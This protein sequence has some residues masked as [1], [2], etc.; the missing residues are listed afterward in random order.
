MQGNRGWDSSPEMAVR[1]AVH[2]LGLRYRV[3]TRPLPALNRRADLVFR[4]TRVA[5]FVDGCYWHGCPEHFVA[6]KSNVDYWSTKIGRN[7]E[8]DQ[9]TNVRLEEAG[10]LAIRVWEHEPPK[11]AA[12]RVERAVR[13]RSA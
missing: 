1:R 3:G 10:W 8:R 9:D 5:V 4:K 12:R 11:E 6:P 7:V 13:Q 2:G